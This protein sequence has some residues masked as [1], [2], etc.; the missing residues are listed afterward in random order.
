MS[1]KIYFIIYFLSH[2]IIYPSLANEKF[3]SWF[4]QNEISMYFTFEFLIPIGIECLAVLEMSNK[5]NGNYIKFKKYNPYSHKSIAYS[6]VHNFVI[7]NYTNKK[8]IG[9]L[10]ER[11]EKYINRYS[12]VTK[13]HFDSIEK[14]CIGIWI[15][16][17]NTYKIHITEKNK[18][19]FRE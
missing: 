6:N 16:P 14:H 1:K 13:E 2:L 15:N 18:E 19:L 7:I 8:F 5:N 12:K 10:S 3:P 9:S 17:L 11:I 4:Y